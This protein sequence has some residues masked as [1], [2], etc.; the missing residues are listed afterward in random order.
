[1]EEESFDNEDIARQL[2]ESF[3]AIKV[4]REARPDIDNVYVEAVRR[5][6]GSAG[7]PL[8]VFL[9]PDGKPFYGGTYFPPEDRFG[10]PGMPKLLE[11][12]AGLWRTSPEK[13]QAASADVTAALQSSATADVSADLTLDT[14]ESAKSLCARSFDAAHGGFGG[15]PKFPQA[16][17][18]TFLLRYF[19]RSGKQD[20]L[21]MAETTL[22][23]MARG[24]IYDHLAG[25]FHR[26][27]VDAEWRVPHFEKML[28]DQ[29]INA[30]AYLEAFQATRHDRHAAV[31][32]GI[33]DYVRND[34]ASPAGGFFAAEDA[35]SEGEEGIFYLWT[36]KEIVAAVGADDGALIAD[37]YGVTD[38]R[39]GP[40]SLQ[41][42]PGGRSPLY[43]PVPV[44]RFAA[45]RG[46]EVELFKQK[47]DGARA[48]LLVARAKR[49][50]PF[51][52]EKIIT[53]WNG[54]MISTLAYG[55]AVLN[56]PAYAEAAAKAADF[57]LARSTKNG[58][59]TRFFHGNTADV[60]GYLDDYA[61]LLMGLVDLYEATFDVRWLQE[62]SRTAEAMLALFQDPQTG[63]LRHSAADHEKLIAASDSFY[64]GAEPAPQS[65]A[66][67]ALLRLG[68][69]TM[70]AAFETQGR[71]LIDAAATEIAGAP[72]GY[73]QML[74]AVDF[75]LGP[76]REIV[77][78][79]PRAAEGTAKLLEV[80]RR[81][82]EPRSVRL[83]HQ[84]GDE[85]LLALVPFLPKQG[86]LN[87]EPTAY[88]CENYVCDLP[89]GD[90][91]RLE[92]LLRDA[93]RRG[94]RTRPDEEVDP[95]PSGRGKGEGMR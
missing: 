92:T 72:L 44:E 82:Y 45:E 49:P 61:F 78:A 59:L 71:A 89:T 22:D 10:R 60:G 84:P 58:R 80:V 3:V 54:L 6:T 7:W 63:I 83:L 62:S 87:D 8:T 77:I 1:M 24:G 53:A 25:G 16:H 2:N 66:A 64:D 39:K 27:S 73:T 50:R 36:R 56:E 81:V 69:L 86:M 68:R 9:T 37:F 19:Q 34:L 30:R 11:T 23:H 38:E 42:L 94:H 51:R 91:A 31:A 20:A 75:A 21:R 12:V 40:R 4:D 35:D 15:A 5:M 26:Y 48:D 47:L 33:L 88:V 79:G 90:A 65:V 13:V 52:D 55:A 43:I 14:L 70:N 17:Q 29:A 18:L 76:V 32:R 93:G 28:Y 41:S 57:L 74:M 67:L 95:S 85:A 46:M